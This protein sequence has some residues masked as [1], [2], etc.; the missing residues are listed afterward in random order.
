VAGPALRLRHG[1]GDALLFG[2]EGDALVHVE[3]G[4]R[5]NMW[6]VGVWDDRMLVDVFDNDA[7]ESSHV[8]CVDKDGK[9]SWRVPGRASVPRGDHVLVLH[10]RDIDA[11]SADGQIIGRIANVGAAHGHKSD[12]VFTFDGDDVLVAN[13]DRVIRC[14]P[15]SSR[16]VWSTS[17]DASALR[18]PVC[19]GRVVAAAPSQYANERT[20]FF[21]D[22][23]TGDL[24]H[25]E[26]AAGK[27]TDLCAVDQDAFVAGSFTKKIVGWR[28]AGAMPQRLTLDHDEKVFE[29]V[30]FGASS[31]A[32]HTGDAIVFWRL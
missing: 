10:D 28:F 22:A 4:K 11:V 25:S 26:N 24:L 3:H 1:E 29:V 32:A 16:V 14:H 27:V 30:P 19:A 2:D 6:R 9:E 8:L 17:L 13:E 18:R 23:Q 20:V 31:L 15:K 5:E 7:D 21:L 12:G